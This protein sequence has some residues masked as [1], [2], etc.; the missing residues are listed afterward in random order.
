MERSC[1]GPSYDDSLLSAGRTG[2]AS[3]RSPL[4]R[5]SSSVG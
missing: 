5:A 2:D 1:E 3:S 4:R